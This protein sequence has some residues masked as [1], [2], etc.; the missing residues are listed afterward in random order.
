M[1]NP[2]VASARCE[3]KLGGTW[4]F[5]LEGGETWPKCHGVLI[6]EVECVLTLLT[7]V[8]IS[9]LQA[10]HTG[11]RA[12]IYHSSFRGSQAE[13]SGMRT[14]YF[15]ADTQEDMNAWI[16]AMNQAAQVL[17]RSS[18][19][20]SV[21]KEGPCQSASYA[22]VG[23]Q[24]RPRGSPHFHRSLTCIKHCPV[25]EVFSDNEF[26]WEEPANTAKTCC[27]LELEGLLEVIW[28]T[29]FIRQGITKA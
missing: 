8:S 5:S 17:S 14:Y 18:L 6:L 26:F 2:P 4:T 25:C 11:M 10:V 27:L 3:N 24:I 12:L 28:S 19:K 15:S 7:W 21:P 23:T 16:R 9:I 13:Q 1:G 22:R 20:R 29:L